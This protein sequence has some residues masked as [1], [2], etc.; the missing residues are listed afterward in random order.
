MMDRRS[1]AAVVLLGACGSSDPVVLEHRFPD[2]T[3]AAGE[4]RSGFCQSWTLGNQDPVHVN[5]VELAAGLGWH[6]SNWYFVPDGDFDGPDGVWDCDE[7]DFDAAAAALRGG[8]LYAQST[9][10]TGEEQRFPA[11]AVVTLPPHAKLVGDSHALNASTS[12]VTTS[13]TLTLDAL[14]ED[15]VTVRLQG[16]ALEY[17]P[18]D[19]PPRSRATFTTECDLA[20]A[21]QRQLGRPVDL[22][23]YYVLMHYHALGAGARVEALDAD[24]V[25]DVVFETGDSIGHTLGDTLD[26]PR[27]MEGKRGLRFSCTFDNPR[28]ESVGWGIGD[29]EMCMLLGFTDSELTWGGGNI[30]GNTVVGTAPDGTVLNEGPCRIVGL[31]PA[32]W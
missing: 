13:L 11:G 24:G 6:H 26:P 2:I 20:G 15:E 5:A 23:F 27:A 16:L 8:V 7:R 3:L 25:G 9:Q 29:Q 17:V 12:S 14:P 22:S 28:D 4:E 10:A 21:H 19:I 18:L 30:D 1:I 32:E 31:A